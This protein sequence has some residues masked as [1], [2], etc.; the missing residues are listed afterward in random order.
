MDP[1]P[2]ILRNSECLLCTLMEPLELALVV[3]TRKNAWSLKLWIRTQFFSGHWHLPP[4]RSAD[5][6]C[7]LAWNLDSR[8]PTQSHACPCHSHGNFPCGPSCAKYLFRVW[9][10]STLS[11]K[12]N[13]G[14]VGDTGQEFGRHLGKG[15]KRWTNLPIAQ[16][17]C[18]LGYLSRSSWNKEKAVTMT[19]WRMLIIP[20]R[21]GTG[22]QPMGRMLLLSGSGWGL[23]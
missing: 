12:Q 9:N 3:L 8:G 19:L 22:H 10:E 13:N 21:Y 17:P 6:M 7:P 5:F 16:S 2:Y 18:V 14:T 20:L 4:A 15:R 23:L 11:S 1:I